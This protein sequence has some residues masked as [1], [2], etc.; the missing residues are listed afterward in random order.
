MAAPKGAKVPQDHK[1][2]EETAKTEAV[3]RDFEGRVITGIEVNYGGHT[4]FVPD[5]RRN[6]WELV[7]DT[8]AMQAG[9][10]SDVGGVFRRYLGNEQYEALKEEFRDEETGRVPREEF[11]AFFGQVVQAANPS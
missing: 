5:E 11:I 8:G 4:V 10:N 1:K 9:R 3:T 6:D 2:K 7:E